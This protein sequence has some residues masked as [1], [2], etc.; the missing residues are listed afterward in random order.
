MP[1]LMEIEKWNPKWNLTMS[2]LTHTNLIYIHQ[3]FHFDPQF[4]SIENFMEGEEIV[5]EKW[6]LRGKVE[7]GT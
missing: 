4:P 3:R 2:L 7:L 1:Q 5:A 6:E